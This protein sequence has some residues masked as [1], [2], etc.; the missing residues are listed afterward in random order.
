MLNCVN[1]LSVGLVHGGLIA[2]AFFIPHKQR[3]EK[4]PLKF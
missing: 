1:N 2:A 4:N 3:G